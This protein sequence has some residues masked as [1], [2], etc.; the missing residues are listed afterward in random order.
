LQPRDINTRKVGPAEPLMPRRRQQTAP[1][2][3]WVQDARGVGR[4]IWRPPTVSARFR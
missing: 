3:G 2:I 4:A 1:G